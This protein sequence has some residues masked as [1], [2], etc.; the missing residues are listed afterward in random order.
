MNNPN[1]TT[2]L[3]DTKCPFTPLLFL[4]LL[5]NPSLRHQEGKRGTWGRRGQLKN[6]NIYNPEK[7]KK[8]VVTRSPFTPPLFFCF[9]YTHL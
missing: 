4:V 1:I 9:G 2:K 8:M 6:D 3:V 5:A 7:R